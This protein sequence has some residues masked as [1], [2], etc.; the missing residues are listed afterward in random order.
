MNKQELITEIS[1]RTG[2]MKK[3][4]EDAVVAFMNVVKDSLVKGEKVSLTGFGIFDIVERA[5]RTGRNPKDGS[6]IQI[7]ASKAPKFKPA[8]TL[9]E[10]VNGR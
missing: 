9:K 3:D 10:A 5:A 2:L 1:N 4:A 6:T 8:K 7:A